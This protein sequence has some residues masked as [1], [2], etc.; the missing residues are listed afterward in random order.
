MV[1]VLEI[2][3]T[4]DQLILLR[5]TK[6]K[7]VS[8]NQNLYKFRQVHRPLWMD[9]CLSVQLTNDHFHI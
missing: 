6:H 8:L 7:V 9:L 4:V 3:S 2:H 1:K 5:T